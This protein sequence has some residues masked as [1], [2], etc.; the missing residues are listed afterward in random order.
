MGK[1]VLVAGFKHETNTF[2]RQPADL[3][4]YRARALYRGPE[5]AARLTDTRTEVGA[6][7]DAARRHGWEL[8]T[9]I[10]ADATPSGPVSDEAFRTICGEIVAAARDAGPFDGVLLNL[11]G[12]MVAERHDDGE[13][14]LLAALR[15]VLGP[16]VP[17]AATLDLHA[18]VT[19]EMADLADIL[20]SYR[21][22]PH[23]DLYEVGTEAADL[24]AR[25]MNGEVR[26]RSFVRR[27][28]MI[29]ALDHGRTTAPGPML[30]VLELAARA[31]AANPAILSYSV[32]AG[33]SR[34]DI[35]QCGPSA[36]IVG[37]GDDAAFGEVA[38][39]LAKAIWER[40]HE[41]TVQTIG[42]EQAMQRIAQRAPGA[43]PTVIAD[44][45]DNPG[46]GGYGDATGLLAALIDA[47]IP[48][49]VFATMYDPQ[50]AAACHAAGAGATLD[51]ELG[52]KVDPALG[53]PI[54]VTGRVER[55]TDG[56]LVYDGPMGKG[57]SIEMG[58]SAVLAIG[59]VRVVVASRRF[60]ALD[61]QFFLHAG[62][63]P[64]AQAVVGLKSA[65][66]FRAAFGPIA[67]EVLVVDVGGGLTSDDLSKL[68]YTKVR[69][70]V[71]P[72]DLD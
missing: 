63:D 57:I 48:G 5:V 31:K 32:N 20:I 22:Y 68:N 13:G 67:S 65:Q 42:V 17:I 4:A 64:A 2:S 19:D 1:R 30:E 26:P 59:N 53:A 52:G 72:L 3:A 70:P 12:A 45:A 18:N 33:F 43:K 21:T 9:P 23:V 44:F 34:A 47:D 61:R 36:V 51:C 38:E 66:H 10:V 46:G 7:L 11:H 27:G 54:A 60:Q 40:R 69:R 39:D 37:D 55:L 71:F 29:F 28:A 58:P 8:A 62:I 15:E 25:T 41:Q 16:G 6:F 14:A 24:L 35:A 56:R 49:T 50:V